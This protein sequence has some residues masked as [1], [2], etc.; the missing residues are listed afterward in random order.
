MAGTR[1]VSVRVILMVS[2]GQRPLFVSLRQWQLPCPV[3][4]PFNDAVL[5]FR[6]TGGADAYGV[7]DFNMMYI[8]NDVF[9]HPFGLAH[10]VLLTRP[11]TIVARSNRAARLPV[12]N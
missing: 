12:V 7:S 5:A 4:V 10:H 8:T 6:Y 1:T 2:D 9:P 11:S 3:G